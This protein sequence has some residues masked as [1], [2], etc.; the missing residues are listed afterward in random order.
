MSPSQLTRQLDLALTQ[1]NES[2]SLATAIRLTVA[3]ILSPETPWRR[4]I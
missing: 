1:A 3:H 4:K 2:L